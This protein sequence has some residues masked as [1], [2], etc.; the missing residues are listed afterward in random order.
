MIPVA[1][2]ARRARRDGQRRSV[3]AP[4]RDTQP[5][6]RRRHRERTDRGAAAERPQL[7][8][9]DRDCRRRGSHR[10]VVQP[11]HAGRWRRLFGGGRP[12]I[13]RRVSARRRHSQQ[14]RTTT[15][16]CRL[17]FPDALQEF[18][19]ETSAQNAQNGFHSGASVNAATKAGTNAFHGDLFE[20][21]R[22]HRF[23]A[24]NPFNAVDPVDRRTAR[25]RPE[26]QPVRRHTR[27]SD[28]RAIAC[29]SSAPTRGRKRT[30]GH[31]TTSGSCRRQ[32]CS[33]AISR[34]LASAACEHARRDHPC[35]AVRRQPHRPGAA[36]PGGRPDRSASLPTTTDPCGRVGVTNP[37][38]IDE[39]AGR[40]AGS[41]IQFVAEP[42]AVR[43]LHGDDV[44]VR[45]A[46]CG[47]RQHACRRRL[48]AVT[49]SCSRSRSA[50]RWC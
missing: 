17:P 26:A 13:R 4:G 15:S 11:Q 49:T 40:S 34:Q 27:R 44:Q 46:V 2:A 9:S 37:R 41:T 18:R 22:N 3:G 50:T 16:T 14:S 32:R 1:L 24:T 48:V 35:G 5:R 25:R 30:S 19:V 45:P 31:R 47:I 23:N 8:R 29:S 42:L 33:P 20:F 7:R 12:A 36:Q 39:T 43:P 6:D 28:R 21:A 38:T 10:S